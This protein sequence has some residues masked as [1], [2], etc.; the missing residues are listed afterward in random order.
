MVDLGAG[1]DQQDAA[2]ARAPLRRAADDRPACGA[3]G[4]DLN[5]TH[6]FDSVTP[7]R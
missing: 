6:N 4:A 2:A 7:Y 3:P 1:G 5:D